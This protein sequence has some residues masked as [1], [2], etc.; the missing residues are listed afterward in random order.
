MI[1]PPDSS[2]LGGLTGAFRAVAFF[3]AATY[4]VLLAAVV[5]Y[6]VLDGPDFI[7][8]LGPVHGIA[9]LV[10]LVLVL[11]IRE[12]QRWGAWWTIVVLVASAVPLGGFWA[13]RHLV[14][15]ERAASAR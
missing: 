11:R 3:E 2:R 10:Y 15:D 9:F 5:L 12:S 1:T 4:L 13:G 7:G 14:Q 8:F 6:R